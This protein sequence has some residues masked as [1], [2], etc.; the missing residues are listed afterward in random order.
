VKILNRSSL[1]ESDCDNCCG[2]SYIEEDEEIAQQQEPQSGTSGDG[3]SNWGPPPGRNKGIHMFNGLS[4][5][6][7]RNEAPIPAKIA[8]LSVC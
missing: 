7:N 2:P 6:V 3:D 1:L 8:R 5:G 4:R